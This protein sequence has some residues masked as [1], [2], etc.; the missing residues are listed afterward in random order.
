[1]CTE[2]CEV[3]CWDASRSLAWRKWYLIDHSTTN[4]DEAEKLQWSM[5]KPQMPPRIV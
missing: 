2:R 3:S 5:I 4:I 1:M